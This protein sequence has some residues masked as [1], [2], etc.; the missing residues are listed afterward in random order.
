M[1]ECINH[2]FPFGW[3]NFVFLFSHQDPQVDC[4]RTSRVQTELN[5]SRENLVGLA[6]LLGCDYIPKVGKTLNLKFTT[7]I[8]QIW[9]SSVNEHFDASL[10]AYQELVKSKLWSSSRHWKDRHFCRGR[11]FSLLSYMYV[12][13]QIVLWCTCNLFCD[14]LRF[15]Q[16]KEDNAGVSEGV[17]K[18]VPHCNLCQHPGEWWP[19]LNSDPH[20]STSGKR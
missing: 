18:K 1:F 20:V 5:L 2:I 10:R 14:H 12:K 16:W 13:A 4:Y 19:A 17:V 6:V 9:R 15:I 8:S 7:S 11:I 3:H